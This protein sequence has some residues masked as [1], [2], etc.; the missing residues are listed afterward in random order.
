MRPEFLEHYPDWR[1]SG[2]EVVLVSLDEMPEGFEK[3]AGG[4]PFIRTTDFQKW[5]STMVKNYHV[6]SIPAMI[7]L[8]K[9]REIL[10]H[11]NS[12]HHMDAWVDWYLGQGNR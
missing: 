1:E 6:H 3:F 10:V 9:R 5:N 4:L 2:V 12:V 7:L 11:P 8:D